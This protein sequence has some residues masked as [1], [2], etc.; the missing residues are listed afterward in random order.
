MF[1]GL[2]EGTGTLL[3]V[4]RRGPDA[5][6]TL[7]ADFDPRGSRWEKASPWTGRA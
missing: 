2:V 5:R 1:T 7:R 3:R 6:M 4:D